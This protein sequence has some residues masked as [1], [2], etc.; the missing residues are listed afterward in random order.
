VSLQRGR[1]PF[2]HGSILSSTNGKTTDACSHALRARCVWEDAVA[3]AGKTDGPGA[4]SWVQ[5]LIAFISAVVGVVAAVQ[6]LGSKVEADRS[7]SQAS[8]FKQALE[9]QANDRAERETNAKYDA[10]A[11]EAVVR[12]LELD[13]RKL[14]A[15]VAEKRERAVM[16]LI[17]ATASESM[18]V[19]LFDVVSSGREVSPAVKQEASSAADAARLVGSTLAGEAPLAQ[20][21]AEPATPA[22]SKSLSLLKGYRV[23]VFAC[24]TADA[25]SSDL[26]R[27]TAEQLVRE[28]KAKPPADAPPVAWEL[29]DLPEV[30]N[31][32][33][34]YGIR[35]NQI[36]FN[37]A[38][39]EEGP[40]VAL[41]ALLEGTEAMKARKVQLERRVVS[42]RTPGYLSVFLCGVPVT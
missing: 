29:K 33:P 26:Q 8:E 1:P 40:S 18:K 19:A 14:D 7:A 41:K 34:G 39:G 31:S 17:A 15:Q 5:G 28:V 2:S 32:S 21:S 42:K 4:L 37:P 30:L 16:A 23:V 35:T 12:L 38:D 13:R 22:T 36:R 11:Y 9:R 25:K 24:Q 6:A 10:V 27:Q 20:A 3:D